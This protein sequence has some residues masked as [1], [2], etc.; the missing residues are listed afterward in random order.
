MTRAPRR[1]RKDLPFQRIALVLS[2]GGGLGAYEVGAF[3][4]FEQARLRPRIVLGV[5]VGAINA[6]I[7]VAH[8][9]VSE[10]LRGVWLK[11]RP[12]SVGMRWATLGA[13]SIGAFLVMLAVFEALLT[14]A[15]V[16]EL[17]L[18]RWVSVSGL[19]T[20]LE[21]PDLLV[22][23]LAWAAV[24]FLGAALL[25]YSDSIEDLL[26]RLTPPADPQRLN[27]ITGAVVLALAILYPVSFL[28]PFAWPHRFHLVFVAFTAGAW[29]LGSSVGGGMGRRL[30][31]RTLPET[32]GRGLWRSAARRRLLDGLLPRSSDHLPLDS[33]T[34]LIL[35]AC[36]VESGRL[37]YFVNWKVGH[38][39]FRDLVRDAL[40]DVVEMH[41]RHELL[42]AA[43]ASSAV[44]VLFEPV[45]IHK[46][47]YVDGGVFS[48]QPLHAVLADDADALLLVLVSPSE[49][50]P[51]LAQDPLVIDVAARLSQIA[52]WR[53][54]QTELRGLPPDWSRDGDP[55]R[56][57]VVEPESGLPGSLL[58]FDPEITKELL[59]RGEADAWS[60]LESAGWL[61]PA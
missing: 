29:L 40:G 45:R 3:R 37:H 13:R 52:N 22:D 34:H 53:D 58:T 28:F 42:Q 39:R 48:N 44:P 59:S 35:S 16:P 50:P 38:G 17:R 61:E 26:A 19:S 11:L 55:A 5:S 43:L 2:G 41:S 36:E 60:A 57:C 1:V 6:L 7:W 46:L 12:A 33:G 47:H 31:L 32:G 23:G 18:G 25:R 27:R 21:W 4:A 49:S 54:L 56:V 9:F 10:R 14:L 8:D 20:A 51:R 24:A 30:L 15:D